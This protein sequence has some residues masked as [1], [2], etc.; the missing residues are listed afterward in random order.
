[1]DEWCSCCSG[2]VSGATKLQVQM[3]KIVVWIGGNNR[4]KES[5]KK[6]KGWRNSGT[7]QRER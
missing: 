5:I 1:M 3:Y 7:G 6:I 4:E 2:L